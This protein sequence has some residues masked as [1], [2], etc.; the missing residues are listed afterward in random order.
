MGAEESERPRSV[1]VEQSKYDCNVQFSIK[2]RTEKI[3]KKK[4]AGVSHYMKI[5]DSQILTDKKIAR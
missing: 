4:A 3:L 5:R 2:K 1:K